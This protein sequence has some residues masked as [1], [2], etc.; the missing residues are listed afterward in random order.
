M[1]FSE[2]KL[3]IRDFVNRSDLSESLLEKAVTV[4][5]QRLQRPLRI[6]P[7]EK[8]A[9][10]SLVVGEDRVTIVGDYLEL[11]ML[12]ANGIPLER[13]SMEY[14]AS[15]DS[16][17]KGTPQYFARELGQF[18]VYPKPD[19]DVS[20]R[21]TYYAEVNAL[22]EPTDTNVFL[23]LSPDVILYGALAFLAE[24]YQDVRGDQWA[25]KFVQHAQELSDQAYEQEYSGSTL[26]F[27][28]TAEY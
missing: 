6:P 22:V 26:S 21:M 5:L 15:L 12:T 7:M 23:R 24:Y 13:K 28:S 27:N 19:T 2:I 9:T 20:V 25:A 8:L 4:S 17:A 3:L 11:I 14:L 16:T 1:T 10:A 18:V